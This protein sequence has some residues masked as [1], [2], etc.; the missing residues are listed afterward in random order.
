MVN[1]WDL[2][3]K[4]D[5]TMAKMTEEVR[6][7]LA[8]MDYVMVHFVSA[9]T[10]ARVHRLLPLIKEAAANHARRI[11]TRELNDLVREAGRAEPAAV[12]QGASAE[13]LLRHPAPRQPARVRLLRQ[14]QRAG[15]LLLPALP[16]E[17]AAADVPFEGT[18]INLYFRTREKA[19][20]GERPVRVRRVLAGG[21]TREIRRGPGSGPP[22]NGVKP[23]YRTSY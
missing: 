12:R 2:I 16:G 13:D 5:R 19:K 18:P 23:A 22:S 8:F 7:R 10:R 11:S 3:E 21:Q 6:E 15:P 14:R 1:K 4:D 9:K 17:S 20:L